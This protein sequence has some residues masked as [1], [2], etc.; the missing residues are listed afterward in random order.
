MGETERMKF[1]IFT[2]K[3]VVIN[4]VSQ[5]IFSEWVFHCAYPC[6]LAI[7]SNSLDFR[8]VGPR[9]LNTQQSLKMC[10]FLPFSEENGKISEKTEGEGEIVF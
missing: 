7:H 6:D 10:W 5:H 2:Y 3:S 1:G 9:G 4:L 8:L